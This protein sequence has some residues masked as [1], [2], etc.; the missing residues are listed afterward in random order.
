MVSGDVTTIKDYWLM[1]LPCGDVITTL[2]FGWCYC[3]SCGCV[4]ATVIVPCF[5]VAEGTVVPVADVVAIVFFIRLVLLPK[6][7]VIATFDF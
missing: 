2:Y 5:V 7:D 1:L 3:Q 6:A 4:F